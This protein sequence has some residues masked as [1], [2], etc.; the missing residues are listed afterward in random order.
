MLLCAAANV[1]RAFHYAILIWKTLTMSA[2]YV[3]LYTVFHC[4]FYFGLG[5]VIYVK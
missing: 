4:L 5:A 2:G 3:Y 1:D